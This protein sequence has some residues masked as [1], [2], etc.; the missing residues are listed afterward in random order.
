MGVGLAGMID[1]L[2]KILGEG[3]SPKTGQTAEGRGM[4]FFQFRF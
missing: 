3:L 4:I 2:G 1:L